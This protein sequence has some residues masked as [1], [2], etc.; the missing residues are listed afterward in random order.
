MRETGIIVT[1]EDIIG[2]HCNFVTMTINCDP[3]SHRPHGI[4]QFDVSL[5]FVYHILVK[6]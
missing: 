1:F 5:V 4:C 2:Y 6:I 3:L